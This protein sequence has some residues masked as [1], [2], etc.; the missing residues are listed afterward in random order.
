MHLLNHLYHPISKS[1]LC[2]AVWTSLSQAGPFPGFLDRSTAIDS[3]TAWANEVI[4]YAPAPGVTETPGYP[5]GSPAIPNNIASRGLGPADGQTVSLGELT[6]SQLAA[7]TVPPGKIAV[8][9]SQPIFNGPGADF[10]IF[11]NAG[12]YYGSPYIFAELAFVEVSS[13][14]S[15]FAR[16]PAISHN[17]Q[18]NGDSVL[19]PDELNAIY[20][21][22]F[23]GADTTNIHNLAGVHPMGSGTPMDLDDLVENFLVTT[24]LVNLHRIKYVRL[25]DIPGNGSFFD[26][27]NNPIFDA[28]ET[29]TSGGFDLDA[30]GATHTI[31]EPTACWLIR[32]VLIAFTTHWRFSEIDNV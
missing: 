19:D 13:N 14:G 31:P 30:V 24:G 20:G 8:S 32:L 4:S 27:Q 18:D 12:D 2:V 10:A 28:W 6:T 23:A 5:P 26:S 3:M 25:V 16:F 22:S 11:E 9:F 17:I 7:Q 29:S 1:M 21:A 15:D